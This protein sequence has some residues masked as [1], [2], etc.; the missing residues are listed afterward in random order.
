MHTSISRK[1]VLHQFLEQGLQD[2]PPVTAGGQHNIGLCVLSRSLCRSAS[3]STRSNSEGNLG[4]HRHVFVPDPTPPRKVTVEGIDECS[5]VN[6]HGEGWTH[7]VTVSRGDDQFLT[8][9]A[10][11]GGDASRLFS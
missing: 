10:L 6:S 4:G 7:T 9:H 11:H 8:L 3:I 5:E 1:V 2:Q